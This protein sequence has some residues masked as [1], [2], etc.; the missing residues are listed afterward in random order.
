MDRQ[1]VRRS[2]APAGQQRP[3]QPLELPGVTQNKRKQV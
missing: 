2:E 1:K 3:G